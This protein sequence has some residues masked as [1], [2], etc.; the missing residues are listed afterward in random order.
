MVDLIK[1]W[2]TSKSWFWKSKVKYAKMEFLLER[3]LYNQRTSYSKAKSSSQIL[4]SI[5]VIGLKSLSGVIFALAFLVLFESYIRTST[6]LLEPLSKE[7]I[8]FNIDQLR[9]YAQLLTTIFSIYF[10]SIGIILS[11]GYTKLRRDI[12]QLLTTEQVGNVYSRILVFSAIF[13]LIATTLESYNIALGVS[14]YAVGTFLTAISSLALFPLGQ[15]LFNFFNLNQLARSEVLPRV[16]RH[17]ENAAKSNNSDSLSNHYSK[18]ARLAF[19]QLCYI[20]DQMKGE[21][22]RLNDNLPALSYDFLMLLQYYLHNKHRIAHQSYWF[23]RRKKHK[24]WF[25]AGDSVTHT[26]LQTSSQLAAEDEADYQ[27]L[28][29]EIIDRLAKHIELAFK[30]EDFKLALDLLSQMSS[31]ISTYSEQFQFSIGM[32]DIKKIQAVIE[33]AFASSKKV[34]KDHN[35]LVLLIGI[36]DAW[37]AFG[38]NLCLETMRRMITFE[39]E[40]RQFFDT[41]IWTSKSLKSLPSFL[42]VELDVVVE[43]INFERHIEEQRLSKPKYLQQLTIQKLLNHY[44][45]LF[46][47]ISDYYAFTIP[48]FVKILT[49][50]DM[51]EPA[52]QVILASL[53]NYWKLP[54]WFDDLSQL[55]KRYR[56]FECYPEKQYLFPE[57]NFNKMREQQTKARND[58]IDMLGKANIVGHIFR[59]EMNDELPDHFGHIYF[60]LAEA[61]INALAENDE[62][63]LSKS[64]P[65]FILLAFMASDSKFLDPELDIN[66]EFRLHLISSILN[67]IMSVLGFAILYGAYYEN[68]RLSEIALDEFDKWVDKAPTKQ[69]YLERMIRLSDLSSLSLSASPRD[70]IRFNWKSSFEH[71][72]RQDGYGDQMGMSR[73]KPHKNKII[74][75]FLRNSFSDATHLFIA[76]HLLPRLDS[77]DFEVGHNISSL[78]RSLE[79]AEDGEQGYL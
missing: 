15:R 10:A 27:W 62:N 67:D 31:R 70:M 18:E 68:S 45:T 6:N 66:D 37:A 54:R 16:V 79:G 2:L 12:I 3:T 7:Q 59:Q 33:T 53:H 24:Q 71:R 69:Q 19:K 41:D 52:T 43:R 74:R 1:V 14:V 73:G 55:V 58:A 72:T 30:A 35:E 50:L 13:C 39:E 46:K 25:F 75:T 9:L 47:D 40:L 32:K 77:V 61:C 38:S 20:D 4:G 60:E 56:E 76:L 36:A 65:M 51:K 5:T 42:Q 49:D 34:E 64:I 78:K 26:A 11:T 44:A 22:K 48:N 23:P 63:R 57:I 29:N 28:E 17:I 8:K 21:T